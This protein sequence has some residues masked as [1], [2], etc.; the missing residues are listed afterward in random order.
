MAMTFA[1]IY[2]SKT[3]FADDFELGALWAYNA[4]TLLRF[5]LSSSP[6]ISRTIS[7]G[8]SNS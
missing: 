5:L 4:Y 2:G 6:E 1:I 8:K 3:E 7:F